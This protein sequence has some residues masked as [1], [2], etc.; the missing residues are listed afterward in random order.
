MSEKFSPILDGGRPMRR[1]IAVAAFA[2]AVT[3]GSMIART[4]APVVSN[5]GASFVAPYTGVAGATSGNIFLSGGTAVAKL[6]AGGAA[7]TP[8]PLSFVLLGIGLLSIVG[9]IRRRLLRA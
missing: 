8:G 3:L 6:P 4:E 1:L 5:G 9:A 2:L 7:A